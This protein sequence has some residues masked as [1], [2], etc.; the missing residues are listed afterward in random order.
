MA[1]SVTQALEPAGPHVTAWWTWVRTTAENTH[2]VFISQPIDQREHVFPLDE[3]P[4]GYSQ[5]ESWM[6]PRILASL[7]KNQRSWVDQRAQTGVHDQSHVLVFYLFKTFTPGSPLEK[8][9]LLRKVLNPSV[10]TNPSS[11]QVELMR[12][13]RDV[14]RLRDLGCFLPDLMLS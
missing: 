3:I 7:P 9:T 1:L 12:W 10:C 5:V 14:R 8:D 13:R 4:V 2:K 6:R 11:A